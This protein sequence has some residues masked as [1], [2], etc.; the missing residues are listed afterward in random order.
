MKTEKSESLTEKE[1][2]RQAEALMMAFAERTGLSSSTPATR[3]LWTDSFAVC[4]FLG[5]SRAVGDEK[6]RELAT[7]LVYQIHRTLGRHRPDDSRK[8]WLSKLSEEEGRKHPT[9]VGLR[10]GKP[11]PEGDFIGRPADDLEWDRDGQYFHY[12]TKWMHALDITARDTC[13]LHYSR[14]ARELAR[15]ARKAFVYQDQTGRLRMYWKMSIDL[16]RPMVHAMGQHDPLD[17]YI[18]TQQL[19][20][21]FQEESSLCGSQVRDDDLDLDEDLSIFAM[22]VQGHDWRTTDPLGLGGLLMDATRLMQLIRQGASSDVDLLVELLRSAEAGLRYW[23]SPGALI[24]PPQQRLAFRELGLAIGLKGV[25][26]MREDPAT[27]NN[28]FID[29]TNIPLQL[30]VVSQYLSLSESI[31]SFWLEPGNRQSR[32]WTEHEDINAVMLAT[33][34]SPRGFLILPGLGGDS[35]SRQ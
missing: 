4:N 25:I 9:L 26:W 15:T 11:L 34:L 13:R 29:G 10:I 1:K 28:S 21:T 3:Y 18:T 16:S 12:L 2:T 7:T 14:W 19:M 23:A 8:G 32:T 20:A 31:I 17:G 27:Y 6:Y 24:Q 5:L 35:D 22:M 30:D 33:A